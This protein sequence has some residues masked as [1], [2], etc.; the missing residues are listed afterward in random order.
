MTRDKARPVYGI[1]SLRH[2]N[3]KGQRDITR[4]SF[5]SLGVIAHME[6]AIEVAIRPD[7]RFIPG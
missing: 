2:A 3:P 6:F 4:V 5:A 1:G 7:N